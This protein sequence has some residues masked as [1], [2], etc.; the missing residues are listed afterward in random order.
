MGLSPSIAVEGLDCTRRD[1]SAATASIVVG[2]E[3]HKASLRSGQAGLS[4]Y[5]EGLEGEQLRQAKDKLLAAYHHE[6]MI[7]TNASFLRGGWKLGED[8]RWHPSCAPT[9]PKASTRFEK[10]FG[11]E[12]NRLSL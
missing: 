5:I 4:A 2:D 7:R 9:R 3:R 1:K 11:M 12:E 6:M 10:R 8:G